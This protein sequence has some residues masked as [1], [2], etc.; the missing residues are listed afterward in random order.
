MPPRDSGKKL[1]PAQIEMLQRWIEQGAE[2]QRHWSLVP[3]RRPVPAI[4]N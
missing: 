1:T 3:I 4:R 2:Y